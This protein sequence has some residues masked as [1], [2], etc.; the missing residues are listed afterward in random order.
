MGLAD[1]GIRSLSN[2]RSGRHRGTSRHGELE[3]LPVHL[4]GTLIASGPEPCSS[5]YV[6]PARVLP[7]NLQKI[8]SQDLPAFSYASKRRSSR[9]DHRLCLLALERLC[10]AALESSSS[11]LLRSGSLLL[12]SLSSSLLDSSDPGDAVAPA[13]TALPCQCRT[14]AALP[15]VRPVFGGIPLV[16]TLGE[17]REDASRLKSIKWTISCDS[18]LTVWISTSSM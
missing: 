4:Q 13:S 6:S 8:H 14:L 18:H 9:S 7:G 2:I 10:S 15:W 5:V 11:S 17:S 3:L 16:L 1:R 12:E